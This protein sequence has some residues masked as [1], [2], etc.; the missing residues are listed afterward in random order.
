V[1]YIHRSSRDIVDLAQHVVERIAQE[2]RITEL[3]E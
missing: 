3:P 1:A 2:L